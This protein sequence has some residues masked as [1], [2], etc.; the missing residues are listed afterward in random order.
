MKISAVDQSLHNAPVGLQKRQRDAL[1]R[2]GLPARL[3][4]SS[5]RY[6]RAATHG[7]VLAAVARV[8]LAI[9]ETAGSTIVELSLNEVNE[10]RAT[11]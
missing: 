4:T 8:R 6:N 1:A 5:L 9:R 7:L 2:V 11:R 3:S 10:R